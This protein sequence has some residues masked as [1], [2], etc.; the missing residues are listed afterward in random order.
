MAGSL[1][2]EASDKT[3]ETL[4]D[5]SNK[6][7]E[8][9]NELSFEKQVGRKVAQIIRQTNLPFVDKKRLADIEADF[10]RFLSTEVPA[11]TF[12]LGSSIP[13]QQR[14][15]ILSAIEKHGAQHLAID[16][17]RPGD[18]R[19]INLAYLGLPDR[20]LTLKW[21]LH[22]AIVHARSLDAD[23]QVKLESQRAWMQ[24]HIQSLSANKFFTHQRA[25]S[26]LEERFADPLCCTLGYPMS[27]ENFAFFKK[28][29]QKEKD[30]SPKRELGH[31]VSHIVQQSLFA[32]YRDSDDIQLPFKDRTVGYGSGRF[33][34]LS[35][36][37]NRPFESSLRAIDDIKSSCTIVDATNGFLISAPK[38]LRDADSFKRWLSKQKK[39]DFGFDAVNGGSLIAIRDAKLV[40]LD[41][42]TWVEADS[43]KD[44]K[45][46]ALLE[47][48]SA[49][50]TVSLKRHYQ[51]YQQ[52]ND[53]P[54]CYVGVLT[55]EGRLAVVAVED[56][57]GPSSIAVRTRSR[58]A[59]VGQIDASEPKVESAASSKELSIK[60]IQAEAATRLEYR[61][62][63][64]NKVKVTLIGI[65]PTVMTETDDDGKE[66]PQS[67]ALVRYLIERPAATKLSV[68]GETLYDGSRRLTTAA[69]IVSGGFWTTWDYESIKD[70]PEVTLPELDFNEEETRVVVREAFRRG[71]NLNSPRVNLVIRNGRDQSQSD[72]TFPDVVVGKQTEAWSQQ[73]ERKRKQRQEMSKQYGNRFA[74]YEMNP[75]DLQEG[76]RL[77]V[78]AYLVKGDVSA[79]VG[80]TS[81]DRESY[82]GYSRLVVAIAGGKTSIQRWGKDGDYIGNSWA[83]K[84]DLKEECES[85][86]GKTVWPA[87][88][89]REEGDV[90]E[91]ATTKN[92][93]KLMVECWRFTPK[94]FKKVEGKNE[95]NGEKTV[96]KDKTLPGQ[97][98]SAWKSVTIDDWQELFEFRVNKNQSVFGTKTFKSDANL[99]IGTF[100]DIGTVANE[101]GFT[102][103]R[104]I[105]TTPAKQFPQLKIE[106]QAAKKGIGQMFF[107]EF[108]AKKPADLDD[109]MEVAS[110]VKIAGP[111]RFEKKKK[112]H[113]LSEKM[114][115]RY[116]NRYAVYEMHPND[117]RKGKRIHL[118]AYLTKG[119]V[120]KPLGSTSLGPESYRDHSRLAVAIVDGKA[121]IERWGSEGY[122]GNAWDLKDDLNKECQALNSETDWPGFRVENKGTSQEIA[123][124]NNGWKLMVE[125]WE[126]TPKG[127]KKAT[128][129]SKEPQQQQPENSLKDPAKEADIAVREVPAPRFP[130]VKREGYTLDQAYYGFGTFRVCDDD[131]LCKHSYATGVQDIRPV[132]GVLRV[133][134]RKSLIL[135][136]DSNNNTDLSA[137]D[138]M[139]PNDLQALILPSQNKIDDRAM[140]AIV[141]FKGLQRLH[142][143]GSKVTDASVLHLKS[144]TQLKYLSL[145][146]CPITDAAIETLKSLRQLETI[147]LWSTYITKNGADRLQLE[148]PQCRVKWLAA[149]DRVHP[150]IEL[151]DLE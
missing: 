149:T 20:L 25:L 42:K 30:A 79:E 86:T 23:K 47:G 96:G 103:L 21:K 44:D 108:Y 8:V 48:P 52:D 66:V 38:K 131:R 115:A 53:A 9:D 123:R 12:K 22:Q 148:L 10:V 70:S 136:I 54:Y 87:L 133:P 73:L 143:G 139:S 56:F 50:S 6:K 58:I 118:G 128:D 62:Q 65:H 121:V 36:K 13:A 2:G 35:F 114:K 24:T 104:V 83:L 113:E 127:A 130:R 85:L 31:V 89:I 27:D 91:I 74:V 107:V 99:A 94:N 150:S 116:G 11:G 39:G 124:N 76:E 55:M 106:I 101:H 100:L 5:S 88:T 71:I 105:Q 61:S 129:K 72:F 16:R 29:L 112:S 78:A 97:I 145:Q 64:Q 33:V 17:Y 43:I 138:S 111:D 32:Q 51:N 19:S 80:V 14:E 18:L 57:S 102:H 93:W 98:E 109:V 3:G 26:A 40:K 46:R 77:H 144:L 134:V 95:S 119:K 34:H 82:T 140:P 132:D 84:D 59:T 117:L 141:R 126:F 147:N 90:Q 60:P 125:F 81:L 7:S 137:L 69:G 63:Q 146:Q 75:N 92:G 135:S 28:Q 45:L 122:T 15:A 142:L 41:V 4:S 67:G 49:G 37:S 110:L 68:G 120:K 1:P 151:K